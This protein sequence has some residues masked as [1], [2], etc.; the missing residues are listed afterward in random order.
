MSRKV[1]PVDPS[2]WR[3]HAPVAAEHA[4]SHSDLPENEW[5]A[6]LRAAPGDEIRESADVRERNQLMFLHGFGAVLSEAVKDALASM[7]ADCAT[8]VQLIYM[9]S[10]SLREVERYTG[11]PKSTV[12]R[13][14][15]EGRRLLAD[16][17]GLELPT[18]E[19][20]RSGSPPPG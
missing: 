4:L 8:V 6:L 12:A 14:R 15:D 3:L 20:P 17:L 16:A 2:N 10:M 13:R 11:I 9:Q 19:D 7:P 18:P 5:D 1:I